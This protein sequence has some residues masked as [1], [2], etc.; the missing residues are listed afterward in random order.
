MA[1][2]ETEEEPRN[3]R[4][5][6]GRKSF[7]QW[8]LPPS[9]VV[10]ERCFHPSSRHLIH[11]AIPVF[12][13]VFHTTHV[14]NLRTLRKFPMACRPLYPE[15]VAHHS[16]RSRRR[17]APWEM[18]PREP[19]PEGQRREGFLADHVDKVASTFP[20]PSPRPSPP[21][22]SPPRK[23]RRWWGRG[24]RT[25]ENALR[26]PFTALPNGVVHTRTPCV[27]PLQGSSLASDLTQG[28]LPAVETL[29]CDVSPLQGAEA[30]STLCGFW[31]NADC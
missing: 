23:Q 24:G 9:R 2:S 19:N 4:K 26:K 21:Q 30:A 20:A 10:F 8:S 22:W 29:G 1:V 15:G 28:A 14:Q 13:R 17:S 6:T 3:T 16:P 25:L 27:E 31:L 12:F 11:T 18:W 7:G 5:R